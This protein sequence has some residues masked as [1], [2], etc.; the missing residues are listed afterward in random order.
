M[1]SCGDISTVDSNLSLLAVNWADYD[2]DLVQP[3]IKLKH[4]IY[5]ICSHTRYPEPE[6]PLL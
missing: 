5:M 4:H 3:D 2:T 1:S 6:V